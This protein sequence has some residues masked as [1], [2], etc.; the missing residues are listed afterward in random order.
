MIQYSS[1]NTQCSLQTEAWCSEITWMAVLYLGPLAYAEDCQVP[2]GRKLGCSLAVASL[3]AFSKKLESCAPC[4]LC[5]DSWFH[6]LPQFSTCPCQ[7]YMYSINYTIQDGSGR[8]EKSQFIC[9]KMN[10]ITA[11]L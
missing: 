7:V 1:R 9:L 8:P 10:D 11:I 6:F 3:S 4:C 2:L 5:L